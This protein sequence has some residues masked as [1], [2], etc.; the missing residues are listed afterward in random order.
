[1]IY[2]TKVKEE[3]LWHNQNKTT[4]IITTKYPIFKCKNG[5]I[6]SIHSKRGDKRDASPAANKSLRNKK[7]VA[8]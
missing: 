7:K 1:M 4:K 3:D 6:V 8:D 2:K 5:N